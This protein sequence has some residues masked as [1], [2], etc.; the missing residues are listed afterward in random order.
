[1][2]VQLLRTA[3]NGLEIVV[4]QPVRGQIASRGDYRQP[5]PVNYA[6]HWGRGVSVGELK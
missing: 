3:G 1:M 4:T 6:R 2:A 5:A